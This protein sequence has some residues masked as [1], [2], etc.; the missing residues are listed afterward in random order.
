M[1]RFMSSPFYRLPDLMWSFSLANISDFAAA[2]CAWGARMREASLPQ[3]TFS[4]CRPLDTDHL[5]LHALLAPGERQGG[6]PLLK[7]GPQRAPCLLSSC[8]RQRRLAARPARG[9]RRPAACR[10]APSGTPPVSTNRH[11]AMSRV[12]A[13]APIPLRRQRLLPCPKRC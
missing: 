13:R 1:W 2:T 10:A 6:Q 12:R 3:T 11:K 7:I 4:P 8:P 9:A 5:I